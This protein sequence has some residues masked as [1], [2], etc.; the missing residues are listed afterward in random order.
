MNDNIAVTG[1]VSLKLVDAD[2]NVKHED[3]FP[4]LVVTT[5]KDFIASRMAGTAS[6][7]MS[8]MAVGTSAIATSVTNTTLGNEV[9]RTTTTVTVTD[10]VVSHYSVFGP[11][12]GTGALREAGIFNSATTNAGA[13]LAR[14]TFALVNKAASDTMYVTWT[15]T[16]K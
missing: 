15:I 7:V 1:W 8:H 4:N 16:I 10:N 3:S 14:T 11:G 9:G 2:G 12:V 6:A 5:G 13:M